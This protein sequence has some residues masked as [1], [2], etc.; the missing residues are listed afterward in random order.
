MDYKLTQSSRIDS[1][2]FTSRNAKAGVSS[3][4]IYN[5][6]LLPTIFNSY[7]ADYYHLINHVQ[8][9]DVSCQKII[10]IKGP[11]A[12]N[13]LRYVSCRNFENIDELR[14]YYTPM[15][16]FNGGLL[17]DTLVY[18]IDEQTIWVSISDSDMFMWFSGLSVN[19]NY[20]VKIKNRYIYTIAIQGPK[21]NIL[22]EELIDKK[23][24]SLPFFSFDFFDFN[25]T[26]VLVSKTGYSKQGGFEF[27]FEEAKIACDFWDFVTKEGKK[28]NIK[29][30]CPNMIER[31]ESSLLSYG[32]DMTFKDTPYDCSLGKYCSIEMSYDF[33]GKVALSNYVKNNDK[34]NIYRVFFGDSDLKIKGKPKCFYKKK[35]IGSITSVIF[36]PKYKKNLGFMIAYENDIFDDNSNNY[37]VKSEYGLIEATISNFN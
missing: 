4:T 6:T 30:G 14:C 29:V 33:V 17:N 7:E 5:K 34:K 32:N 20:N 16:D 1:T 27:L 10:E 9:W 24:V 23:I 2:P 26:K 21:A 18:S 35:E 22:T 8:M 11:D 12:L 37:F 15:T 3:Y 31:V 13:F 28:F 36:S 25:K 19:T